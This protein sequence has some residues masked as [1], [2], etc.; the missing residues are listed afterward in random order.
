MTAEVMWLIVIVMTVMMMHYELVGGFRPVAICRYSRQCIHPLATMPKIMEFDMGSLEITRVLG[1][2]DIQVDEAILEA[3]MKELKE[4]GD[5]KILQSSN[6]GN[7]MNKNG[8]MTSVRVFEGRTI[9]GTKC[10]LKEFLPIGLS[11]GK[12]E[13]QTTQ[14]LRRKWNEICRLR[15]SNKTRS[16]EELFSLTENEDIMEHNKEVMSWSTYTEPPFPVL[17]GTLR[18][19]ST[20]ELPEFRSKWLKQFPRTPPPEA[21]NLWLIYMWDESTF[22]ALRRYA[23]LPQVLEGY[24]YFDKNS[25]D[26][27]RWR[28]IR[29]I[30]RR[31]LEAVDFLHRCGFAHNAI[32]SE[33]LWLTT[34]NQLAIRDLSAKLTDLGVCQRFTDLGPFG[35]EAAMED[36]YQLGFVF[37]EL[38]VSS[39]CD[40]NTGAQI[41]REMLSKVHLRF[42]ECCIFR[43]LVNIFVG[44]TLFEAGKERA[45]KKLLYRIE[46]IDIRQ[47]SS[48]EFQQVYEKL[49]SSD[50]KEFLQFCNSIKPWSAPM[51]ILQRNEG[52]AWRLIFK[53]LARGRLF[54]ETKNKPL[55]VTGRGLIKEYSDVLFE[56]TYADTAPPNW[57]QALRDNNIK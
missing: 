22:R 46:D 31:S 27:K 18:P 41:A 47:L 4:S 3:A 33:S 15:E 29:K 14:A 1:K 44:F 16:V 2:I 56:D 54:D 48:K 23:P 43:S 49:C 34:T 38:V 51:S 13:L 10:F 8:R 17:L 26:D 24:D 36:F 11:L 19:D 25:R 9:Y 39:F 37:I 21:G 42:F 28:F 45:T 6:Q 55:K 50:F 20:I 7:P 35:R 30:M 53:L 12:R 5:K 40:D 57:L 32:S 52:A